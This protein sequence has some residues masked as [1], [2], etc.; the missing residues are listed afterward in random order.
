M[1]KYL[2]FAFNIWRLIKDNYTV[3]TIVCG[4]KTYI[5]NTN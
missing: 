4:F 5:F 1:L 2:L 3:Y